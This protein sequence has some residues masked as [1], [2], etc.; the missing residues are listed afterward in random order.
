M[1]SKTL[2]S[3]F[4]WSKVEA[5]FRDIGGEPP[6]LQV[7]LINQFTFLVQKESKSEKVT[8]DVYENWI[9]ADVNRSFYNV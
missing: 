3:P 7:L 4:S 9:I 6:Q 2:E 1:Y 8:R 5:E